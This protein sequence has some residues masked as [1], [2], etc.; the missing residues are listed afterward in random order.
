[1]YATFL[2]RMLL[3][4]FSP[5]FDEKQIEANYATQ[6][7]EA[8]PCFKLCMVCRSRNGGGTSDMNILRSEAISVIVKGNMT[9]CWHI[10]EVTIQSYA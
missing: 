9:K 10:S 3:W 2:V 8:S 6:Y 4:T 5:F 7:S 1:M